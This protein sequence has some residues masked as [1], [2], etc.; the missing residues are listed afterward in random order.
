ML[1]N[2]GNYRKAKKSMEE[3]YLMID[4]VAT[5]LKVS[6]VTVYSFINSGKLESVKIGKSRRVTLTALQRFIEHHIDRKDARH[7]QHQ[8][9]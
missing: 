6:R 7:G 8:N 5:R 2:A 9:D 4:E 1:Y 3:Q